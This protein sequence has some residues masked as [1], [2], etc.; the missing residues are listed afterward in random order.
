MTLY[1]WLNE[2][3][4]ARGSAKALVYRDTYLSWRGLQH[5]VE[6]RAQEFAAM[7]IGEGHWVGL[8]LGNV[9]DFAT[10]AL[11]LSKLGATVVPLDPTTGARDLAM[12]LEAAPLRGLITRPRGGIDTAPAVPSVKGTRPQEPPESRR[13]LQGTLLTCSIYK[14]RKDAAPKGAAVVLFTSD[15]SGEPK[16][17]LRTAANLE[18]GVENLKTTLEVTPD[19]RILTTAPLYHAFGF[20]LGMVLA[21]RHG[22]TLYLED[23]VAP[24]RIVKLLRDQEIDLLPGMPSLYAGL[25]RLPTA[26][27][28]KIKHARYLSAGSPLSPAIAEAFRERWGIKVMAMYHT[29]ETQTVTVDRKGASPDSVG[30]AADGVEVRTDATGVVWVRS[31]AVTGRAIGAGVGNRMVGDKIPVGGLDGEGWLRTGDL[32]R[33]DRTGRLFLSGREDDLVKVDGKRVALGEVEGCLESFSKVKSAKARVITDSQGG[34][35]VVAR[36]V[37]LSKCDAEEIIDHCAR[38]LAPYKVPRRIE[39]SEL[40]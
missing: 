31:A 39:F 1:K 2:A 15:S 24:R 10:M 3:V 34:P 37:V 29:T 35:I 23:E 5:R 32:G 25:A 6:R 8:M 28:L 9:P 19:D 26:K 4:K 11:A 40:P 36:V 38:N 30:K 13:R 7:G 14:Q 18:A 21:L 22:A 16:G 12:I 27:P 33:V 17:V 20:D